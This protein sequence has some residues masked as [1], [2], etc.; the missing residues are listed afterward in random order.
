MAD[1]ERILITGAAH[2]A[3]AAIMKAVA[4]AGA[5]VIGLD[6]RSHAGGHPIYLPVLLGKMDDSNFL[7]EVMAEVEHVVHAF[8]DRRHGV[9]YD[10]LA[11]T[12]LDAGR[13]IFEAAAKAKCKRFIFISNARICSF[14]EDFIDESTKVQ[15]ET[16]LEQSIVDAEIMLRGLAGRLPDAPRLIIL[17]S[18]PVY[19]LPGIPIESPWL[20]IPPILGLL[21]DLIPGVSGG[22]RCHWVHGD[23]LGRAALHLTKAKLDSER[24]DVF[25]IA[26]DTPVTVGEFV[27]HLVEAYGFPLGI[28]IP[29]PF[30]LLNG[31]LKVIDRRGLRS[32]A[33]RVVGRL[34]QEVCE[35]HPL[36]TDFRPQLEF[37]ALKSVL[38]PAVIDNER[39][40]STGFELRYP[41]F[42]VGLPEALSNYQRLRILPR[43]QTDRH[44]ETAK[45]R[46]RLSFSETL[47][48]T[49]TTGETQTEE[50][51]ISMTLT[52]SAPRVQVSNV[53]NLW[54]L[55][56]T[57]TVAE[58]ATNVQIE[59][60]LTGS[61]WR[62]SNLVYE[63]G[64]IGDDSRAYRLEGTKK[65]R[66]RNPL[67]TSTHMDFRI[68]DDSGKQVGV[69]TMVFDLR[70]DFFWFLRSFG[71]ERGGSPKKTANP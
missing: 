41:D 53:D 29:F 59:G 39:L 34:W 61:L 30:G 31:L 36:E 21:F 1:D 54:N 20:A 65:L 22:S 18:A 19:A 37:V 67:K 43:R 51:P 33:G 15:P 10:E 50:R 35:R 28:K 44:L 66:L 57:L 58:L 26:D 63:L 40:K 47:H 23:D 69:G 60:T 25:H 55:D 64:F 71:I 9:P 42:R 16:P 5:N 70:S 12:Q 8:V 48:G 49:L 56:G 6:Q 14:S 24:G 4:E 52:M 46:I 32:L 11:Q 7:A 17:R 38:K 62:K 27:S 45:Q 13:R 3:G 2:G 68:W